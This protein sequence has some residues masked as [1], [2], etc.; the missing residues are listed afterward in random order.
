MSQTNLWKILQ[1][2]FNNFIQ[3]TASK[4]QKNIS[5][6]QARNMQNAYINAEKCAVNPPYEEIAKQLCAEKTEIFNAACYYLE[7]ISSQKTQ[8]KEPIIRYLQTYAKSV[9][10]PDSRK[11]Q[12]IDLIEKI[13]AK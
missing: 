7:K 1:K 6:S 12:I 9:K 11:R 4:K 8:D 2:L 3:N 5:A 10:M 13:N